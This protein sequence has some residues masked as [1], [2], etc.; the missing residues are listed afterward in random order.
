MRR[1]QA[2]VLLGSLFVLSA[3]AI[4]YELLIGTVSS[5][6]LGS[7][8]LHFSLTIGMFLS[9]LGLGAYLSKFLSEPLLPKF[10]GI[11]LCLGLVGGC[12]ALMLHLGDAWMP[13]YYLLLGFVVGLIGTL[14]GLEIPIVTRLLEQAGGLREVIARVLAFDYLGALAASLVFPLLLLPMLGNMRTAFFTGLV[15]WAVG[16]FNLIVFRKEIAERGRLWALALGIGAL[17]GTGFAYSFQLV[18]FSDALHYQDKVVLSRQTP[19]QRIVVTRWNQDMRLFLNGNLQFCS[20]DEYRYHEP[21]IHLP[22]LAA[23][24]R[25]SILVLGGG[26]GLALREILKYPDV[27][28][29]ILVDL[30]A[31]MVKLA[32]THPL[33]TRLNGGTLDDPRVRCVAED[34]FNYLKNNAQRFNVII[35]DLPDPSEA[36]LGKLYS[37]AFYRMARQ[38]LAADGVL[39][40]QATS[41]FLARKPFWCIHQTLT[42]VF[43]TVMPYHAYVPSFGLWGFHLAFAYPTDPEQIKT[44]IVQHLGQV[45]GLRYLTPTNTRHA[46]DFDGDTGPVSV[47]S[48]SLEQLEIL[49]LYQ[50]SYWEFH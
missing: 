12:S 36:A 40:T 43:P 8:V 35:A 2:V 22:L 50:D 45:P 28:G 3:C 18:A 16:V 10:V 25:D 11:E 1:D 23:P 14:A 44:T 15:N 13:N 42:E 29:V 41:P 26:D 32:R 27:K 33:F 38:N 5:Y 17:L 37:S 46:F 31:D 7:S 6:L 20:V 34:A 24:R 9:F 4:L 39:V 21:L 19:Y 49:G 48:N 30:D 47:P